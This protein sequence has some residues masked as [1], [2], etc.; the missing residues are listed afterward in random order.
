MRYSNVSMPIDDGTEVARWASLPRSRDIESPIPPYL[1]VI[2]NQIFGCKNAH[3]G[4]CVQVAQWS[5]LGPR[6]QGVERSNPP[7]SLLK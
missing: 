3:Y 1:V 7:T 4:W 6:Y 2:I 5:P